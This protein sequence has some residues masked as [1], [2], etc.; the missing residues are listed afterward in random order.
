[1]KPTA[2]LA[3]IS[4]NA[5]DAIDEEVPHNEL[6]YCKACMRITQFD[7]YEKHPMLGKRYKEVAKA[8]EVEWAHRFIREHHELST[9]QFAE[10]V[11]RLGVHPQRPK[12]WQA[13]EELLICTCS[14]L[15]GRR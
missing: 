3:L 15:R 1:M 2:N 8:D 14:A 5:C 10:R 6:G 13:I 7:D 11:V 9:D 12:A 4:C